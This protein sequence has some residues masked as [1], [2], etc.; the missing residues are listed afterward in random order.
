MSL[1]GID[2]GARRVGVAVA[3]AGS[4]RA[5]PL[6][7]FRRRSVEQDAAI[8]SRLRDEHAASELVV[9]LPLNIDGSEGPQAAATR[10]WAARVALLVG[11]PV[12]WRDERYTSLIAET[13]TAR[14]RRSSTGAAPGAR[15]RSARRA[16]VDRE[17]ARLILERELDARARLRPR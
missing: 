16:R 6:T 7:T 15:A 4:P 2:L 3:P 13:E 17:A 9:G 11:L 8:L 12:T 5:R 1:L 10:D 14:P